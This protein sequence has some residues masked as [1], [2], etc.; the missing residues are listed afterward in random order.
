MSWSQSSGVVSTKLTKRSQPALLTRMSVGPTSSLELGDRRADGVIVGNVD[1]RGG[2]PEISPAIFFAPSRF[3]SN[4][5][6]G[7]P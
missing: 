1:A 4:T 3:L 5:P 7:R 6:T 2:S